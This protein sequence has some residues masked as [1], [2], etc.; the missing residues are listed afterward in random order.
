MD[1]YHVTLKMDETTFEVRAASERE[2]EE[3]A[4]GRVDDGTMHTRVCKVVKVEGTQT[5]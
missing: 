1:T 2:A 3:I 4:I 5:A